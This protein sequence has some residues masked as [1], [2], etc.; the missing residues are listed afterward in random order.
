MEGEL[1]SLYKPVRARLHPANQ[2][3][4]EPQPEP[5]KHGP[6]RTSDADAA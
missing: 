5:A 6:R 3:T 4:T 1:R 2:P